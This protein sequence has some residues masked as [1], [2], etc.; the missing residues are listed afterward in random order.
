MLNRL[1]LFVS[2]WVRPN[3]LGWS[4]LKDWWLVLRPLTLM[5]SVLNKNKFE[6]W[7]TLKFRIRMFFFFIREEWFIYLKCFFFIRGEWFI[8]FFKYKRIFLFLFKIILVHGTF[9]ESYPSLF[10][11]FSKS[12]LH[13]SLYYI[14][15][16]LTLF[17]IF[18]FFSEE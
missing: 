3:R 12:L 5:C 17:L 13:S 7:H 2:H 10:F 14:P 15:Y 16:S 8:S 1:K 4:G 18:F 9:N 6:A 11:S